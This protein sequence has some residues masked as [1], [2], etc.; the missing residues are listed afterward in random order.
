[1]QLSNKVDKRI[2]KQELLNSTDSFVTIS[3]YRY[4]FI[5]N[6]QALRDELYRAWY[7]MG[8]KGRIYLAQEGINAQLSV[9]EKYLEIFDTHLQMFSLT[10]NIRRNFAVEQGKSF[11]KLKILVRDKI[12]ADGID[13][14][15]FDSSNCGVHLGAK[16]FNEMMAHPDAVIIDFRNHYE[17]EVGHFQNAVL[18][19]VDTF[20]EQL[21]K[22]AEEFKDNKDKPILM[23]CTGGIRCEKA[24]AYMKHKGFNQVFQLEGGIIKYAK[25]CKEHGIEPK[26]I[27]K[28]FVFDERLGERITEDIIA[29]CHQCGKPAD[30]HTNCIN[31]ACHLLFIQCDNCKEA[32][33]NCCSPECMDFIKLPIEQQKELRKGIDKGRQVFKKGRAEHLKMIAAKDADKAEAHPYVQS[34]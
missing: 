1:M 34:N 10:K 11:F 21:P 27:G 14:P 20:R 12:V 23:Y 18:P 29:V 6:P 3:F 31:E 8:V 33:E 16:E 4:K 26:F 25:D 24:S 30:T 9:P 13:D 2:L 7:A 5:E 22:V 15:T 32:F 17:S 19:D 28:N